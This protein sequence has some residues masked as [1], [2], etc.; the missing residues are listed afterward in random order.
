MEEF[1]EFAGIPDTEENEY[2]RSPLDF[3]PA[4]CYNYRNTTRMNEDLG[5]GDEDG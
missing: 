2:R 5:T 4:H 3:F 1:L